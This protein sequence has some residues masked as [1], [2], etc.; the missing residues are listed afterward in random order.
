MRGR[1]GS[2]D[3]VEAAK[4]HVPLI[5]CKSNRPMERGRNG[6]RYF[7]NPPQPHM[8]IQDFIED[9]N[10][11]C[12]INVLSWQKISTPRKPEDPIP[13]YGGMRV[14][15]N[16][17]AAMTLSS[18]FGAKVQPVIFAVM[19]NP[20]ILRLSGKTAP[21]PS[22]RDALVEL[23]IDFVEAMNPDVRFKREFTVLR[24]RDLAGELK[25]IWLAVQAKRERER[26]ENG[27]REA[28]KFRENKDEQWREEVRQRAPRNI[29]NELEQNILSS[30]VHGQDKEKIEIASQELFMRQ[31]E[32]RRYQTEKIEVGAVEGQH[33]RDGE[34]S[35]LSLTTT[36]DLTTTPSTDPLNT[37][38]TQHIGAINYE[39]ESVYSLIRSHYEQEFNRTEGNTINTT[40]SSDEMSEQSFPNVYT[41]TCFSNSRNETGDNVVFPVFSES[42]VRDPVSTLEVASGI[43]VNTSVI[44]SNTSRIAVQQEEN[45]FL[46][47]KHQEAS[48]RNENSSSLNEQFSICDSTDSSIRHN[49]YECKTHVKGN[50]NESNEG[51]PCKNS[52]LLTSEHRGVPIEKDNLF[53]GLSGE[54]MFSN[55]IAQ[56]PNVA[57]RSHEDHLPT[58]GESQGVKFPL[59]TD[60][61]TVAIP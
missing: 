15:H 26:G 27:R 40:L 58:L 35:S 59:G 60:H 37:N 45:Y 23:M 19:A 28:E 44:E 48:P 30:P 61:N 32:D 31:E 12:F 52:G 43:E 10:E 22:D 18:H 55:N 46:S 25:D 8:C 7:R 5:L 29:D 56:V 14:P 9:T 41:A 11:P 51:K 6:A 16:S 39:E 57:G 50:E 24:D 36:T 1:Y 54:A 17:S 33:H 13:L 34:I 49:V 4:N 53:S 21:D 38:S 2:A 47:H 42:V 20:E 3:A